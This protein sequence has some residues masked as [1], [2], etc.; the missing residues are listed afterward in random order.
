MYLTKHTREMIRLVEFHL[1]GVARH[2]CAQHAR[3]VFIP[4]RNLGDFAQQVSEY[5]IDNM[6]AVT[7][8]AHENAAGYGVRTAPHMRTAY[9]T[10]LDN[11]LRKRALTIHGAPLV[12]E[13]P[14]SRA[15]DRESRTQATLAE[16]ERQMRGFQCVV[17]V[18]RTPSARITVTHTGKVNPDKQTSSHFRDDL[19]LALMIAVFYG[20]RHLH[21]FSTLQHHTHV[22]RFVH[23]RFEQPNSGRKRPGVE[24]ARVALVT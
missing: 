9:A 7:V 13:S 4:E 14:Y 6:P 15:P 1:R 20:Q 3:V 22:N 24:S 5:V 16:F 17:R 11:L 21:G 18:P 23:S 12:C 8:M 19:V 10:E 2:P